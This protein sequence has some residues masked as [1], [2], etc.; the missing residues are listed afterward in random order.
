MVFAVAPCWLVIGGFAI[1][2]YEGMDKGVEVRVRG[3]V[4]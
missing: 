2:I 1:L 3:E 4:R